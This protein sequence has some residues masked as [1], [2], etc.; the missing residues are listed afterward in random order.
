MKQKSPRNSGFKTS[1]DLIELSDAFRRHASYKDPLL[2]QELVKEA[3]Q[4][5][6]L[7]TWYD[8]SE[9]FRHKDLSMKLTV[10]VMRIASLAVQLKLDEVTLPV[11]GDPRSPFASFFTHRV[12]PE[13]QL[14]VK[15][16]LQSGEYA[17]DLSHIGRIDKRIKT[18]LDEGL[19]GMANIKTDLR[20]KW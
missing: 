15:V 11:S 12:L 14:P 9:S 2:V 13:L 1:V 19:R 10:S 18:S 3:R 16:S 8:Y 20:C 6:T 5:T 7:S 4:F 17:K